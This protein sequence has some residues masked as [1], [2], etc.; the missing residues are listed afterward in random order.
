MSQKGECSICFGRDAAIRWRECVIFCDPG[1]DLMHVP[2]APFSL[3]ESRMRP[4]SVRVFK[5]VY[6]GL[7]ADKCYEKYE[8]RIQLW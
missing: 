6:R 3:T 8:T 5:A 4:W 2:G 1:A 7:L